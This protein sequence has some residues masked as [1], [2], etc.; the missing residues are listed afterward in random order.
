ME[1]PINQIG[2]VLNTS[3]NQMSQNRPVPKSQADLK[4]DNNE[5][6]SKYIIENNRVVFEKYDEY[7]KL[8]IKVPLPCKSVNKKL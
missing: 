7:G 6:S 5:S 2:N 8:I 1:D 3:R 4:A